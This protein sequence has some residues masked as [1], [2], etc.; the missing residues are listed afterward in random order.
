[1]PSFFECRSP[2]D[3]AYFAEIASSNPIAGSEGLVGRMNEAP[4]GGSARPDAHLVKKVKEITSKIKQGGDMQ[5]KASYGR[6]S[7]TLD[8]N[9][10]VR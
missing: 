2:G 4:V 10:G 7:I 6:S 3:G 8:A 1:M 9:F 5:W